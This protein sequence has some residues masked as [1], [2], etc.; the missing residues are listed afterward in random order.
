MEPHQRVSGDESKSEGI[1]KALA[2]AGL[3]EIEPAQFPDR[4]KEVRHVAMGL[5]GELLEL[6]NRVAERESVAHSLGTLKVLENKL[7]KPGGDG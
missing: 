6:Q 4:I 5:L 3:I 1:W 2:D 7:G